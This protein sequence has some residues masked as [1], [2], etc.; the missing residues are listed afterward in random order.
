MIDLEKDRLAVDL[1][2]PKIVFFIWVI[3]VAEIIVHGDGFL[4]CARFLIVATGSCPKQLGVRQLGAGVLVAD[5]AVA[6]LSRRDDAVR[7]TDAAESV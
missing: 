3:G 6:P 5:D 4:R 1:K 2:R 7:D